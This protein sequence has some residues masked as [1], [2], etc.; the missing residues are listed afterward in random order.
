MTS[1]ERYNMLLKDLLDDGVVIEAK[2]SKWYW[3]AL[4]GLLFVISFG[5]IRFM[6]TSVTTIGNRIGVPAG[7]DTWGDDA[8]R[9]EVLLH[10]AV[11][12]RQYKRF[13]FGNVWVGVVPVGL[14]YLFL[15]FP[16][17]IAYCRA[18]LEWEG[19][20]ESIRAIIQLEGV[21]A[22]MDDKSFFVSQFTSA[23]YLYMWPFK[24]QVEKWFDEA[25]RRIAIEEG[26]I[27]E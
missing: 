12:I 21:T 16:V 17:G 22:A 1:T 2:A 20:E 27:V 15:P 11:H 19:Y 14:A 5:K 26:V 8:G 18:R 23:N 9:Y 13:G 10:E 24:S 25:V 6:E 4:A 7:W 3:K